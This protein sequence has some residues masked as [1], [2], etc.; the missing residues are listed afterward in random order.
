VSGDGDGC[1]FCDVAGCLGCALFHDERT[2]TAKIY[3]L[4]F[5][6]GSFEGFDCG[7]NNICNCDLFNSGSFCNLIYDVCF[8]HNCMFL[9]ISKFQNRNANLRKNLTFTKTILIFLG[10]LSYFCTCI[11]NVSDMKCFLQPYQ[12]PDIYL[13]VF[14]AESAVLLGRIGSWYDDEEE[15]IL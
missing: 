4:A 12:S 15:I 7:I 14:D 3:G 11:L 5:L 2:E 9:I 13:Y 10:F 1:A 6:Y 8:C